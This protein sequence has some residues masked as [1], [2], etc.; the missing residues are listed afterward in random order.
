MIVNRRADDPGVRGARASIL[1]PMT[2]AAIIIVVFGAAVAAAIGYAAAL[3]VDRFWALH[4]APL[5]GAAAGGAFGLLLSLATI[6]GWFQAGLSWTEAKV[7]VDEVLPYMQLIR[8]REPALYERIET[9]VIRDQNDGV[10]AEQVRA[11]AKTLVMSYVADKTIY[12]PDQLTYELFATTRDQL[13]YLS[14][15][16]DPQAC[17]DLALGRAKGDLDSRL[18][19]ELIER[20]DN[21][22]TRVIATP[23]AQDAPRMPAEQFAE[24]ATRA[25]AE[26]A[27]TAGVP[28]ETVDSLL[29][30]AGDAAKTCKVMK[31][32]FDSV[33][34]QPV[35][36]AASALR[37]MAAGER[38]PTQ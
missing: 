17:A 30:G 3:G 21:N 1:T 18:S 5:W 9:S 11:N 10:S 20:G 38:S 12:L 4:V 23:P 16:G 31:V 35:E 27:Q 26:A 24:L 2:W 25:F 34:A 29:T 6:G 33:L 19:A 13:A 8:A 32:F 15:Q 36:V 22:T 7:A 37:T 14:E 28:A